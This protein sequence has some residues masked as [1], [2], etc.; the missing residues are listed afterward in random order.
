MTKKITVK[1]FKCPKCGQAIH[2]DI[3]EDVLIEF[4]KSKNVVI[5]PKFVKGKR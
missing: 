4:L 1:G 2:F 3:N 5:E